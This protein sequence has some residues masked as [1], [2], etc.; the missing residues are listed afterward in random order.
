MILAGGEGTRLYPLTMERAK[1]SVPFGGNY[2]IIDFVLSNFINSGIFKIYVLTQFKA[3]SLMQHIRLGWRISGMENSFIETI[4]PQMRTGKRWYEGT[5]DSVF[6]NM[7]LIE[8]ES[9]D[10]VLVFGGDHI[11]KMDIN[12]LL[13]FHEKT[14]AVLTVSAISVPKEQASQFGI[15]EVDDNWRM[16]GFVEKPKQEPKTVPGDPTKVLASMG[17][18][19]FDRDI[20]CEVLEEDSKKLDSS[21]DFGKDIIP[22]LYPKHEVYVFDFRRN[23]VPGEDATS[24]VYWRD[25][26]TIESFFDSNIDLVGVTPEINLYNF[27]WPIRGYFPAMP[28]AK[29]VHYSPSRTGQAINSMV[30]AGTIIS[31]AEVY[32]SVLGSA[33]KVHSFSKIKHSVLMGYNDVGR[34]TRINRTIMDKGAKVGSNLTIGFNREDDLNLPGCMVSESGI[35]VIPKGVV[36]E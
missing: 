25:V 6:Q 1:P 20:L 11:Y 14:K 16:I 24:S 9:P 17:N 19:I 8:E 4:P 23:K 15:I 33:V 34:N 36:I 35:V 30:S 3:Q 31:G 10:Q 2:R 26:G 5:A 22:T 7:N 12:Q 18:Y 21:H 27:K 29:F 32:E 13:R 28:G